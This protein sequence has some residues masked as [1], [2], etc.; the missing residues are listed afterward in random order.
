MLA[1]FPLLALLLLWP[2]LLGGQALLPAEFLSEM[3]PWS[4][5]APARPEGTTGQWN[6]LQWDGMAEFYPWRMHAAREMRAGRIPLWNPHILCGTPFLAN[7]Q[8]APLYPLHALYYLI[9]Q[10][11]VLLMPW[12]AWLHLSLAGVFAYFLAR[13]LGARTVAAALA[14]IA[15]ELSGFAV[16]WLELPSFISVACWIP[17]AMLCTLRGVREQSWR[18]TLSAG[19]VTGL[20]LLA[21]HLQIGFY[22]LL[23][24]GLCW[25]WETATLLRSSRSL[26][27]LLTCGAMA[28]VI[29]GA[30]LALASPQFI[31]S[32]EL[33]RMSHRAGAASAAGFTSY[34]ERALP[35]QNWITLLVPDFYGLPARGDFW[36][37]WGYLAPNV[38]EYAGHV[39]AAAF[40]LALVGLVAGFAVDRRAWLIGLL[41]VL[42]LLLATG[43]PPTGLFYFGIPGFAQ[44]GSP[45]RVLVLFCLA[46][47]ILAGLGTEW[48]LRRTEARWSCPV[49]ALLAAAAATVLI[50]LFLAWGPPT[51]LVPKETPASVEAI[52][53]TSVPALTR[54]LLLAG[55]AA[56]LPLLLAAFLRD[57]DAR[58]RSTV[59]GWAMCAVVAGGL[60]LVGGSYNPTASRE[61]VY[62]PTPLTDALA[63]AGSRVIT[64]N[65]NWSLIRTPQAL[66]PP[67]SSLAYGW[68]DVQGYDSLW[69][70][71]YR[72]LVDALSVGEV[73]S[74]SPPENGNIVFVKRSDSPLLPLF[75]APLLVDPLS[76]MPQKLP[77]AVPEA[78]GTTWFAADDAR[79]ME[80]MRGSF[81]GAPDRVA[82][83]SPDTAPTDDYV[84]RSENLPP[85]IPAE[86]RRHSPGHVTAALMSPRPSLLVLVEG[87]APGWKATLRTEDGVSRRVPVRRVNT[88]FQGVLVPEGL[89]RVDW[90]YEPASFRVGL[91][92]GLAALGALLAGLIGTKPRTRRAV[93]SLRDS[94]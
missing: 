65:R 67:N 70:G 88:A 91:F 38:Q 89:A 55:L 48:V 17:L 59:M 44:S 75:A 22:G 74:A 51:D 41:A 32:L 69:L 80:A 87:F 42:S 20:M 16:A 3:S 36:G 79:G 46:Q 68:R 21:G 86:L 11:V 10:T 56:G 85:A 33:S 49:P 12:V 28:A 47:A 53:L 18:W 90:R 15:F 54:A 23:A 84:F 61:Q 2:A 93:A 78:Y 76:P 26:R 37:L 1:L 13:Y 5:G 81:S 7:S 30:G 27:G 14:G 50:A 62:P 29:F 39:G 24:V 71:H 34:V 40:I 52:S 63:A 35:P 64:I 83:I 66:L 82:Y 77:K 31:P 25:T 9:P 92:I 6:V 19:A 60:L 58:R 57:S 4:A 72:P 45:A 8:S 94:D 73:G 43:S